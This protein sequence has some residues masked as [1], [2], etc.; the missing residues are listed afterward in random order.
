MP[1]FIARLENLCRTYS[2]GLDSRMIQPGIHHI[3][4]ARS[5]G[6]W[7]KTHIRNGNY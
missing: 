4:L 3:T 5:E 6:W 2:D 1:I 7:E